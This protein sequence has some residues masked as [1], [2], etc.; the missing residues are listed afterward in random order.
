MGQERPL[1]RFQHSSMRLVLFRT[2]VNCYG[3]P[4]AATEMLPD[5]QK[6]HITELPEGYRLV[7]IE[8]DSFVVRKPN[9]ETLVV[10]QDGRQVGVT[11]LPC[12]HHADKTARLG[13]DSA[14]SAYTNPMD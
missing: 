10:P 4:T 12:V 2:N 8:S 5:R 1:L 7:A 3:P 9:G 6:L 11:T 14:I 13:R